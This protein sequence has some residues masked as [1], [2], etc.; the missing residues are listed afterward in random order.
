M[1]PVS[2]GRSN[3][4]RN[5]NYV[6]SVCICGHLATRNRELWKLWFGDR[7]GCAEKPA[8]DRIHQVVSI[9]KLKVICLYSLLYVQG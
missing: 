5:M 2:K 8:V 7:H 9:P 1:K 3:F 6:S 4:Q